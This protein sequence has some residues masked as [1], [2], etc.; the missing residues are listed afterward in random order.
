V[1][2]PQINVQQLITF[3]FVA[4]EESFSVASE[5]LFI[6]QPAVTRQI[7]SLEG[8][9][10]VKLINVKRKR[11]HL[12]KAGERLVTYAESVI[13][14]VMMAENFLKS[15]RV[16]SLRIGV[17]TTITLYLTP[18][19]DKFKEL[20][21]SVML[22]VREGPSLT[23]IEDLLDFKH[24]IC[25]VGPLPAIDK[26]LR[27][28]SIPEVERMVL[29]ASPEYPLARKSEVKW[30]DLVEYPLIL[31]A[32]GSTSREVILRHFASRKLTPMIGAEVDNVE[33]AKQLALQ[34]KG[35]AMMFLPCVREEVALGKL[36]IIPVV[37]G[38]IKL[39]IDV[40]TNRECAS[41][42]LLKAFVGIIEK[43]FNY[44]LCEDGSLRQRPMVI[45]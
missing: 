45:S 11:V 27:V 6:T 31:Q 16:N 37:N 13:S 10:G 8:Q 42:P 21:P 43:R 20:F 1:Q 18:M 36:T 29:V 39:G 40:V 32:E 15:C 25:L 34:Q 33:C 4:K 9:F 28:A 38:E 7:K 24:D 2:L 22:S 23:L 12:T 44:P 3:C 41:S 35:M 30:E 14:Q 26:K 19:I 17:A 5:K